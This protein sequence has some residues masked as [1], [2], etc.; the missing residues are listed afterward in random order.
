MARMVEHGKKAQ[1]LFLSIASGRTKIKG[2]EYRNAPSSSGALTPQ[3]G[4]IDFS[5]PLPQY[6]SREVLMIDSDAG[7]LKLNE[8]EDENFQAVADQAV[9]FLETIFKEHAGRFLLQVVSGRFNAF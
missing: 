4:S 1:D 5:N 3:N 2:M 9:S 7:A 6:C 8:S